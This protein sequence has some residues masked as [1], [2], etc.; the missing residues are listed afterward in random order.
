MKQYYVY[1]MSSY[2]RVLYIG[3]TNNL[4]RRVAEHKEGV[5]CGFTQKYKIRFLVYYEI[6]NNIW[7]AINREKQ[8]KKWR[9]E[10]KIRLIKSV[11]PKWDDLSCADFFT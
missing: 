8:L 4:G 3:V 10:K 9:R 6:I 2:S 5:I 1:I 7:N 11:N